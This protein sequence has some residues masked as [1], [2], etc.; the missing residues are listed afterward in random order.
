MEVGWTPFPKEIVGVWRCSLKGQVQVVGPSHSIISSEQGRNRD[1]GRFR[2]QEGFPFPVIPSENFP[3]A[4]AGPYGKG[5]IQSGRGPPDSRG[6]TFPVI[7]S[8]QTGR[9]YIHTK[10]A[11]PYFSTIGHI[12]GSRN[13]PLPPATPFFDPF[14]APDSL[15]YV[16]IVISCQC[17]YEFV[18]NPHYPFSRLTKSWYWNIH[19][20]NE[21]SQPTYSNTPLFATSPSNIPKPLNDIIEF[22]F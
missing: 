7:P 18:T 14:S 1:K 13:H 2:A 4:C 16:R 12:I 11:P 22:S 3:Q 21:H 17:Q 10:K 15:R 5:R 19:P 9:A 6:P 8:E 20:H